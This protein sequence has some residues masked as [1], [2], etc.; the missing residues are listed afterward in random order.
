MKLSPNHYWV[1]CFGMSLLHFSL[2][3]KNNYNT[4]LKIYLRNPSIWYLKIK[5]TFKI[6]ICDLKKN[7]YRLSTCTKLEMLHHLLTDI[8]YDSLPHIWPHPALCLN[9]GTPLHTSRVHPVSACGLAY[10]PCLWSQLTSQ[11][12]QLRPRIDVYLY[13]F[14]SHFQKM[15]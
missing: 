3:L 2:V 1:K 5:K 14:P 8:N 9:Y 6:F 15:C 10:P 13:I 4:Y 7:N 11:I 12:S